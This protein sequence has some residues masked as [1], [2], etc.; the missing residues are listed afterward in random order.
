MSAGKRY[1]AIPANLVT[2]FLGVG[3]TT[4]IRSLLARKPAGEHWAVLVNEFGEVGVD[5]SLFQEDDIGV[6]QIPGGCVC[7]ASSQMFTVGLN[8]LI[9]QEDP[10]RILIEPTGL[11]HPAEIV[12]NLTTPPFAEVLD[13]RATLTVMD[14]RHLSSPRHRE[15]PNWGEQM[16]QADVLLANKADQYTDG[17]VAALEQALRDWPAPRPRVVTT[18]QGQLEISELDRP[19]LPRDEGSAVHA[20]DHHGHH[21]DAEHGHAGHDHGSHAHEGTGIESAGAEEWIVLDGHGEAHSTRSWLFP[22]SARFDHQALADMLDAL[23]RGRAKGV[24][25]TERGWHALNR[26]DG[27]G[28]LEPVTTEDP[29]R[30]PRLEIIQP[31]PPAVDPEQLN[32]QLQSLATGSSC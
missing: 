10:D 14:A 27:E 2:G 28:G 8:R 23:D 7:C 24:L 17:D 21:H 29:S 12:R 22:E 11:G 30:R 4:T 13:L 15:H 19:R 6:T 18:R 16:R 32:R 26:V 9:R 3:K 5:G 20:H 25:A 1:Q 31:D